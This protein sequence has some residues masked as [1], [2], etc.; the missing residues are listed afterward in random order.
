M[1]RLEQLLTTERPWLTD[2]GL[3]TYMIFG[4]GH[5]DPT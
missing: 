4:V 2:G 3:E 1:N 5:V